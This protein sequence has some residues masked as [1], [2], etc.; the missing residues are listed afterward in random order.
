MK[1]LYLGA[2]FFAIL[3]SLIPGKGINE[4]P[5][6]SA[7]GAA[8]FF[9]GPSGGTFTV[10]S[11]FTVSIYVNT[12]GNF[13]NAIE[14]NLSFPPDK[15]QVVSPTAGKSIIQMW[16]VQPTFSNSE[17]SL[18]F[19][20]AIPTPGINTEAGLISTI[21]FR[22]KS[23]G[24]AA[25][26][27]LDGSRALLNDGRGTNVLGQKTD[28]L[29][30]LIL[31]P[32]AGPL[33]TSPTNP[34]QEKWYS[35]K[36]VV[37]RWE[38]APETQGFSYILNKLAS[39]E[40]DDIPEGLKTSVAYKDLADDTYYFHIKSLRAGIWGGVTTYA[41][42]I[43]NSPPAA[44]EINISPSAYTSNRRP[45]ID[46]GTT[47]SASGIDHY[48]L[49][50]ISLEPQAQK[51]ERNSPADNTPFFIEATSPYFRQL[52]IGRYDIVVR[53][54]DRAGNFFQTAK[55]LTIVNP[56]FEIIRGQGLRLAGV[57]TIRWLYVG[58]IAGFLLLLFGY[59]SRTVWKWH[60]RLEKQ[61]LDGAHKHP[62]V[63]EKL[64]ALQQ[65]QKEYGTGR[66]LMLPIIW[67]TIIAA[68]VSLVFGAVPAR[69]EENAAGRMAVEPPIV[70]LFPKS[71]SND[72]ILYIGGRAGAPDAQVIIYIQNSETGGTLSYFAP[73]D[74]TGAWFYSLPQFLPVGKYTIWTQLKV[75]DELS[76][77][78][79]RIDLGVAPTAV[80]LGE[81]RLSYEEL[82]LIFTIILAAAFAGLTIFILY[83]FHRGR[84]KKRRLAA[85]IR[86]VE[87]SVR[88]GFAVLRRDI[89]AELAVVRKA[90][91]SKTLSIEER[92]REEQL[93]RDLEWVRG[94]I[95]KEI[96]DVEN[97]QETDKTEIQ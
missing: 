42:N 84:A 13:I 30:V 16:V 10:G 66:D 3:S 48:E 2:V 82:Y 56:I 49:K 20:G 93:L 77:P 86:E 63:A 11:T 90:K 39:D 6:V 97:I 83:H 32:P 24:V 65:K 14:A 74:K 37:F 5:A 35:T 73:T 1:P 71:V 26:R 4:P 50:I 92:E 87:E 80:Q 72:E 7:Q 78:S 25:L 9:V 54:Y 68:G 53:A 57:Y 81:R 12:G 85:E 91:L 88:R 15:L 46:F 64:E 95:G 38:A 23:T 18:R 70:T 67:L 96:W 76:P 60:R 94:N 8:S 47:D 19:Q 36:N 21:T 61:L 45:I 17:G 51:S 62:L 41:V 58:I 27:F 40:P 55:R 28:G 69:A 33:V 52:E 22:V 59:I 29:Y 79:S 89:E 31:P 44:F 75:G 43:D 34:D